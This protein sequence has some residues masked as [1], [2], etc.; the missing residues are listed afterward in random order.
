M[1]LNGMIPPHNDTRADSDEPNSNTKTKIIC[2]DGDNKTLNYTDKT[3]TKR[4]MPSQTPEYI[5][6]S[7]S[8]A[9]KQNTLTIQGM[10]NEKIHLHI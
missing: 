5:R 7:N 2:P 10:E 8:R 6:N 3:S 4:L 1:Y 9:S